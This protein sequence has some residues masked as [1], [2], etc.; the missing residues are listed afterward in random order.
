M[1]APYTPFFPDMIPGRRL[2]GRHAD[3]TRPSFQVGSVVI[4]EAALQGLIE[5]LG[6]AFLVGIGIL[7]LDMLLMWILRW[8]AG[9]GGSPHGTRISRLLR[10]ERAGDGV[11]TIHGS[12]ISRFSSFMLL[13][14]FFVPMVMIL[15]AATFG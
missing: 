12:I 2:K 10:L 11:F 9:R 7:I 14:V 8:H 15:A 13:S 1:T 5:R 3:A 4:S 6:H